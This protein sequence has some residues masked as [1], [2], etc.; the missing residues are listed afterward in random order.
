MGIGRAHRKRQYN[1]IIIEGKVK[2][3]LLPGWTKYDV[4][5]FSQSRQDANKYGEFYIVIRYS[6][7]EDI[8]HSQCG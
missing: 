2:I 6:Q 7:L 3:F 4:K 5:C 1:R 8:Y